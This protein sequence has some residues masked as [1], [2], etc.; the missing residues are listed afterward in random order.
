MKIKD[1]LLLFAATAAA[2]PVQAAWFGDIGQYNQAGQSSLEFFYEGGERDIQ[3]KSDP[4]ARLELSDH[5]FGTQYIY[6]VGQGLETL[7]RVTPFTGRINF[8]GSGFNPDVW[9]IGTGLHWSPPEPLGPVRV[10]VM[11]AVDFHQGTKSSRN[12]MNWLELSM[13][14]GLSVPVTKIVNLFGGISFVRPDIEF[15]SQGVKTK[16]E[17]EDTMGGFLGASLSPNKAWTLATELHFGNESA[18]G[19]SARY[20][21][22]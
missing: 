3:L 6:G 7:L 14:G 9:G 21:F 5:R 4:N 10:G 11:A 12:N 22:Q 15:E 1:A 19:F 17:M 13:A 2:A 18:A 16:W 20:N 8:E